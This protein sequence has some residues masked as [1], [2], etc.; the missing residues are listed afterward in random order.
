MNIKNLQTVNLSGAV[1]IEVILY[2][3]K[4]QLTFKILFVITEGPC[5]AY[6]GNPQ[7]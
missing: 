4:V 6:N 2:R 3:S 5:T 1:N 7:V